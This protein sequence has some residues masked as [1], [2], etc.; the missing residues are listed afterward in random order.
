MTDLGLILILNI[1]TKLSHFPHNSKRIPTFPH[2]HRTH[3]K[4]LKSTTH[5]YDIYFVNLHFGKI[6]FV[7]ILI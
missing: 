6:E 2:P 5:I 7:T 4:K 1:N 3:K